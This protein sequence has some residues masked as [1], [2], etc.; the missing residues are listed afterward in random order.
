MKGTENPLPVCLV[1][2]TQIEAKPAMQYLQAKPVHHHASLFTGSSPRSE[3]KILI[4]LTGMGPKVAYTAIRALLITQS[5]SK[6]INLGAAGSLQ[7]H[8]QVG[9]LC[10]IDCAHMEESSDEAFQD[11][12]QI[13]LRPLPDFPQ[14]RLVS[15]HTPVFDDKRRVRLATDADMVDMEGAAIAWACHQHSTPCQMLKG[16]TDFAGTDERKR[17][18]ENLSEVS[19]AL[20]TEL[21]QRE[22]IF[23]S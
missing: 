6:V 23:V 9:D 22:D 13:P 4:L 12:D 21:F 15:V 10:T 20:T 2:A 3:Q 16:V 19:Q 1:F 11:L 14:H 18:H 8:L 5:I 17:L 7:P